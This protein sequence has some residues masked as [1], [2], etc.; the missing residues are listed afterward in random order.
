MLFS[1]GLT[2]KT[3]VK[4]NKLDYNILKRRYSMAKNFFK[5]M[6]IIL[7]SMSVIAIAAIWIIGLFVQE[8]PTSAFEEFSSEAQ[9][10]DRMFL[11]K[12]T[13]YMVGFPSYI[14]NHF[15]ESDYLEQTNF[16]LDYSQQKYYAI[17]ES[18]STKDKKFTHNGYII[19]IHS[20]MN[21]KTNP[22]EFV[23][24]RLVIASQFDRKIDES[25]DNKYFD[26]GGV[27]TVFNDIGIVD[28]DGEY[29]VTVENIEVRYFVK[30]AS[31]IDDKSQISAFFKHNGGVYKIYLETSYNL[32]G[33]DLN[34]CMEELNKIIEGI[35]TE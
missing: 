25:I 2:D 14:P 7:G 18:F 22:L 11:D 33:L 24:E 23:E 15:L 27:P 8:V 12:K 30:N 13:E 19:S 28:K 6:L 1:Q 31:G 26:D 21:S 10:Q 20:R 4:H 32:S 9:L 3:L 34:W 29:F 17:V 5:S 16:I 35:V